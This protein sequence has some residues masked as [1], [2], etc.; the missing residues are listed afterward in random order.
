[1]NIKG[2]PAAAGLYDPRW[3]HDACGVA[4]YVDIK[5]R[6]SHE[7]I[8]Q[9]LKALKNLGHRGASGYEKTTGDG[10]GIL[11][12]IPQRFH[13]YVCGELGIV[14]PDPGHYGVG[15]LFMPQDAELAEKCR[16][17]VA[18][19]IAETG[20]EMLGWRDV[21][22]NNAEIGNGSKAGEPD[23]Q[24]VFIGSGE[25]SP[26]DLERRLYLLRRR[27]EKSGAPFYIASLS[28]RTLI[29]KGMLTADQ[30]P[31]YY[32]DLTHPLIE[33]ALALVHQRFSTNTFP[34]WSLAH[35]Y[36]Y[37]AHN[38][39][40]NTL[41]GN[42]N[43][44]H[45]REQLLESDIFGDELADLLPVIQP[46]GSDSAA[47]DNV[48]EFLLMTGRSLPQTLMMLIPEP[49][50]HHTM[51]GDAERAFYD[52]HSAIMEPWDGPAAVAFTDG[53][54]IGATL[55]RNG[56][57]PGRYYVTSDD[58]IIMASEVG[59]L[60][61]APEDVVYKGRLEPGKMLLIDTIQGRIIPDEEIKAEIAAAEPYAEWLAESRVKLADLPA[62]SRSNGLVG[63]EFISTREPG[64]GPEPGG[65]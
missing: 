3:E 30:L 49:W 34:T 10:A 56:L 40:I 13:R 65:V 31:G 4:F 26:A 47:L 6:K 54:L 62:E 46:G 21:P 22:Q 41:R 16:D 39:E 57:R 9:G 48:L 45:A 12:Q 7:I 36:R 63:V 44:M 55:D 8:A 24:Q 33:S 2:F 14:L 60:D 1:M 43:W 50:Q 17:I 28:A 32:P 59:V 52:F 5:G 61:I 18:T 23:I 42:I 37:I 15:M 25:Q 51:M 53:E 27:I 19:K 11:I 38:G 64:S 29:Y 35:P 20:L 58:R